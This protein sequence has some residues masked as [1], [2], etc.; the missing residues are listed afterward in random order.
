MFSSLVLRLKLKELCLAFW[1]LDLKVRCLAN[2]VNSRDFD[3]LFSIF[4]GLYIFFFFFV[5]PSVGK[6]RELIVRN[7]LLIC[8][9]FSS[10]HDAILY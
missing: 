9:S 2:L 10:F 1:I 3:L 4:L 7:P 8:A 5:P 6:L